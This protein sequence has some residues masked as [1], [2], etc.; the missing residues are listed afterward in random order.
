MDST[1]LILGAEVLL[2]IGLAVLVL[3]LSYVQ[4]QARL[5]AWG[6]LALQ[7]GLTCE[8]GSA[9]W[10]PIR[11]TGSFRGRG[12]MVETF[13]RGAGRS[14]RHYTRAVVSVNNPVQLRLLLSEEG[15]WARVE[16]W[17][18]AQDIVLGDEAFDSRFKIQG[19]PVVSVQRLLAAPDLRQY[20][21]AL[22]GAH[23]AVEGSQAWNEA[24]GIELKVE[25]LRQWLDV[26]WRVAEGV[27]RL[28][29]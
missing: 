23:V 9:P 18:G 21:L 11:V 15:A 29:L 5:R 6:E 22:P 24:R 28:N 20:L 7:T 2:V 1:T 10:S 8:S 27:D 3:G 26:V 4:R 25:T 19:Q 17:L 13:T 14:R 16:K 12:V